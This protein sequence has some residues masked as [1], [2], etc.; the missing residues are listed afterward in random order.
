MAG[1]NLKEG[2]YSGNDV[3][4]DELWSLFNYVFSDSCKKTNTYKF[5]L[6]KSI[7]D[8]VYDL[9][10]TEDMYFLS[11]DYLFSKFTENYWNLVN[12]YELRQMSYNGK[13]EYSRIERIIRE[14]VQKNA[15]PPTVSFLSLSEKDRAHIIKQVSNDCK[16]CVI[17][18]LY[19]DFEGKLYSF[20]L[21][22][23]GLFLGAKAHKFIA[24]YKVEIERLNY[25]AWARFLET[26]NDDE[27]LT[28]VLEKLDHATPKRVDLSTYQQILY[29]EFCENNCF[30]CGKKLKRSI[31]VDHFIPW[32]FMKTDNLWN[33]VLACPECNYKKSNSLTSEIF[34]R[35]IEA[36]NK[37]I[38]LETN[39]SPIIE[40][41]FS[42]Y[43]IG[44]IKK[45][46]NYA[47]MSG[48]RE[49]NI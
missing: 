36:R 30:Y 9:K 16:K 27:A 25:Y 38:K 2:L 11:F 29:N 22:G 17:G 7:C 37:S 43:Y 20:N 24:K 4:E 21:K 5:G 42:N 14:C 28:R 35:K 18:A 39:I 1:W 33:F 49:R 12:K 34:V 40:K 48:L 26:I 19:N 45:V 23:D 6:I 32:S 31:H 47:R 41:E 10:C 3:T 44:L 8:S 46:W 15:I 13:S